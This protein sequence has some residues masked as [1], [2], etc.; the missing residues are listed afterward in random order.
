MSVETM[1][2]KIHQSINTL[3]ASLNHKEDRRKIAV[4]R[5]EQ[6]QKDV[7]LETKNVDDIDNEI[8]EVESQLEDQKE[9]IALITAYDLEHKEAFRKIKESFNT[10]HAKHINGSITDS[11][12]MEYREVAGYGLLVEEGE[13]TEEEQAKEPTQ[14]VA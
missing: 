3:Q 14:A 11:D 13:D 6:H 1:L 4:S 5:L 7:A 12:I 10:L 9:K 8:L 2:E